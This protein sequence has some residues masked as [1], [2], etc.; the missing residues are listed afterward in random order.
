MIK[1]DVTTLLKVIIRVYVLQI[2]KK[3]V[4]TE[5]IEKEKYLIIVKFFFHFLVVSS[6][7]GF[8]LFSRARGKTKSFVKRCD[9]ALF[10]K[11]GELSY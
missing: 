8:P 11:E 7:N 6:L 3:N 4:A 1:Q 2:K 9:D 10:F 5:V